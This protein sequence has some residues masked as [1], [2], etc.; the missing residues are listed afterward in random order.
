MKI[1]SISHVYN[2][3]LYLEDSYNYLKSI[4]VNEFAYIDN[5][6]TDDSMYFLQKTPDIFWKVFNTGEAF[7]LGMLQK[8]M[9]A[10]TKLFAP[11]WIIYTD[12]DLYYSFDGT[13]LEEIKKAEDQG[14]NQISTI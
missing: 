8:E 11:D 1:L 9:L 4:G 6:S 12:P 10:F 2:E 7:N 5:M 3:N 13:L 14:C